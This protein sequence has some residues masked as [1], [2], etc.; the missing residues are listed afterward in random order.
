MS[1]ISRPATLGATQALCHNVLHLTMQFCGHTTLPSLPSS[2]LWHSLRKFLLASAHQLVGKQSRSPPPLATA[3]PVGKK[4]QLEVNVE[5][6]LTAKYISCLKSKVSACL[7]LAAFFHFLHASYTWYRLDN[8][9]GQREGGSSSN[10]C[11]TPLGL[12]VCWQIYFMTSLSCYWARWLKL[13]SSLR[14]NALHKYH[15][16]VGLSSH[17]KTNYVH[18]A[19]WW[20]TRLVSS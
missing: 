16:Y 7:Q 15:V 2:P 14:A 9:Q 11:A 17:L 12:F 20:A 8:H 1:L 10:C 3:S 4:M 13:F 5:F 18:T 19:N 6:D